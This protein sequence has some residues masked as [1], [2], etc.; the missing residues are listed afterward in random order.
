MSF[1][2]NLKRELGSGFFKDKWRKIFVKNKSVWFD[3]HQLAGL[4]NRTESCLG[5]TWPWPPP[6]IFPYNIIFPKKKKKIVACTA[7]VMRIMLL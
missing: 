3:L 1:Q 7:D 2:L 4:A 5:L 6:K